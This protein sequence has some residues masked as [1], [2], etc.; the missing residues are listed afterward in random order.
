MMTYNDHMSRWSRNTTAESRLNVAMFPANQAALTSHTMGILPWTR[1][2]GRELYTAPGI[3]VSKPDVSLP[4]L[5]I[6]SVIVGLQVLG[7]L[8]LGCWIAMRPTWARTLDAMAVARVAASL[9]SGLLPPFRTT[10]Q[11]D[12]DKLAPVDGLIGA[13]IR[14]DA[15]EQQHGSGV[16]RRVDADEEIEMRALSVASTVGKEPTSEAVPAST[17]NGAIS[18]LGVGAPGLVSRRWGK[19]AKSVLSL[20]L[21][22]A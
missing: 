18:E 1:D 6:L 20:D 17:A 11:K 19:Q 16:V 15:V 4:S 9:D 12:W 22:Y 13:R 14:V 10:G 7:L 5:I 3:R 2:T 21:T 8:W